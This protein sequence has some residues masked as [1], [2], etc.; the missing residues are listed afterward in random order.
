VVAEAVN[1]TDGRRRRRNRV[2]VSVVPPT[3]TGRKYCRRRRL[4]GFY[5]YLNEA[6]AHATDRRRSR[7]RTL[8][9]IITSRACPYYADGA[10]GER[11]LLL[12][13]LLLL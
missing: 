6:G 5:R 7:R 11:L 12:L 2:S 9:Y 10:R 4:F 1:R 3:T 13:L 8:R